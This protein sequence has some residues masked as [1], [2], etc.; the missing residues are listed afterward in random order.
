[1]EASYSVTTPKTPLKQCKSDDRLRTQTLYYDTGYTGAEIILTTGLS[2]DKIR[3]ALSHRLT[4]Q[5]H[6]RG[7][8]V[9][10][11]APQRKHLI[12]WFTSSAVNRLTKWKDIP[13]LL[14]WNCGEKAIRTA[15][16]KEGF[17]RRI[18][19]RKPPLTEQHRRDRLA[20]AWDHV[21]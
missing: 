13:A 8:R 18:V 10:L 9:V 14:E 2:R 6:A 1:M 5:Y 3:Y 16:K 15:F 7:R 21:F 19:R 12:Q 4:P 17:V 11:N 20:R